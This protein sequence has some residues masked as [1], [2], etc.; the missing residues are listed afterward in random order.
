MFRKSTKTFLG[1]IVAA[2]VLAGAPSSAS[3]GRFGSKS[4]A[5]NKSTATK[6]RVHRRSGKERATGK[7]G[8]RSFGPVRNSS[9]A[10]VEKAPAP[11]PRDRRVL[12]KQ[13]S[14][15]GSHGAKP[16]TLR[17]QASVEKHRLAKEK[18]RKKNE[19]KLDAIMRGA[20]QLARIEVMVMKEKG[21]PIDDYT[22][23][24]LVHERLGKLLA[25]GELSFDL[26][27]Y[28]PNFYLNDAP[29]KTG[30]AKSVLF[31]HK[32]PNDPE[33][34]RVEIWAFKPGDMTTPHEHPGRGATWVLDGSVSELHYRPARDREVTLARTVTRNRGHFGLVSEKPGGTNFIH[35]VGAPPNRSGMSH[36][37]HMYGTVVTKGA[38]DDLLDR[39]DHHGQS[40][41]MAQ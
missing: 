36:T 34:L 9:L 13:A 40:S 14:R 19:R 26:S 12:L 20:I 32:T 4:Q 41:R 28:V 22:F 2:L 15:P 10:A 27:P 29:G 35:V 39:A 7:V 24:T 11:F 1:V 38:R 37:L 17:S 16:F 23:M 18:T 31:E 21:Q 33:Y 25:R 30:A 6:S 5:R 8:D 3:A